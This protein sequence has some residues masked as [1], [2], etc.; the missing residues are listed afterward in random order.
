LNNL[1]QIATVYVK[2]ENEFNKSLTSVPIQSRELLATVEFTNVSI[3]HRG[4]NVN[5]LENKKRITA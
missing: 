4:A 3:S 5:T 1:P 2:S